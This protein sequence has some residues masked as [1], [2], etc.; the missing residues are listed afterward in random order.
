MIEELKSKDVCYVL[1]TYV[2]Q[3]LKKINESI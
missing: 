1:S 2:N 3:Q